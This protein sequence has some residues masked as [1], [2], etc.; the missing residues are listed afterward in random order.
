MLSFGSD[1]HCI[2]DFKLGSDGGPTASNSLWLFKIHASPWFIFSFVCCLLFGVYCLVVS[3]YD[4]GGTTVVDADVVA[5]RW[6]GYSSTDYKLL[7]VGNGS[8]KL[9]KKKIIKNI[10]I[11]G[12]VNQ[13]YV[14]LE[15]L[16]LFGEI[17]MFQ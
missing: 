6:F 14:N 1:D 15:L 5:S 13:N 17:F 9:K 2:K 8:T 10:I 16:R 12:S 11:R 4:G 3:L 7:D